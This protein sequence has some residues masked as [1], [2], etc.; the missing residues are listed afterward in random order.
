VT[1]RRRR[2]ALLT[3]TGAG[4]VLAT[5]A[6]VI[7]GPQFLGSS[8]D[9]DTAVAGAPALSTSVNHSS[10]A[11]SPGA[12]AAA[13]QVT[14]KGTL[15]TL[16][17]LLP[18][19]LRV[20]GPTMWGDNFIGVSVVA[21]DGKGISRIEATVQTTKARMT[22]DNEPPTSDCKVRPDGSILIT[23]QSKVVRPVDGGVI[24]NGVLVY[25]PDRTVIHLASTNAPQM[26]ATKPTAPQPVLSI[27]QL[28]K[29]ADSGLWKFPPA[30][31]GEDQNP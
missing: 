5:T 4:A 6:T 24:T 7:G 18:G 31:Y 2:T 3:F 21:D 14:P 10:G 19:S 27:A 29:M 12:P 15:E 30:S 1:L 23:S 25:R 17:E 11:P 22:C 16:T 8:S 13:E 26:K 9:V 20:S 28:T